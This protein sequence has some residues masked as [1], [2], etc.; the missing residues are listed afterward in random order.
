[1][2]SNAQQDLFDRARMG[3]IVVG[4]RK[5]EEWK[6]FATEAI[7]LHLACDSGDTLAFRMDDHARRLIIE[8]DPSE[9]V[10]AIGWH[11]DDER[12]LEIL[13]SRLASRGV[14]P[15]RIE[16]N[17]ARDRGVD[18]LHRFK[19]PKG[20]LIELFTQPVLDDRPL[21]I[22]TSGFVVGR[23]GMGHVSLMSQEPARNIAFWQE[24]LDARLSDTIDLARGNKVVMQVSFL[25]VNQ[26]HHSVAIA[27]TTS[28]SIDMFRTRI[29]HLNLE[30]ATIDDLS[31]AFN[32]CKKMGY[33]LTRNIGQHPNDKELSFY[34]STPSGFEL[35]IGWDALEVN[36]NTWQEGQT[37]AEMSTWGHEVPGRFSSELSFSHVVQGI[38]S[39]SR[40]EFLPW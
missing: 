29:Q 10:Q 23:S 13:L 20:L 15:E 8:N 5:F 3:Y 34:V 4:S 2:S 36:E 14:T 40:S 31:D 6:R 22:R 27:A 37:F 12:V 17:E 9:D 21:D 25:R 30:V 7:G 19:G 32:R 26:R 33:K 39:L 38:R 11:L 24:L 16:G 18:A 28:G 35:E 1:M